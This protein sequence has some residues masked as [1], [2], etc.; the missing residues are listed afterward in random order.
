[1]KSFFHL[2]FPLMVAL[3]FGE[4]VRDSAAVESVTALKQES[5]ERDP[6]WEGYNN[7]V[8]PKRIPTVA[9]DFGYSPS[10]F[11]G[12]E[13]GEIGGRVWRS[14]TRASY[15]GAIPPRTLRDKLTASGTFAVTATS[16]SSGP[17][18]GWFNS[19]H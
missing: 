9:Q 3:T 12:K 18:F 6:K 11:A 2:A 14:S 7:H 19:E 4:A 13:K 17:F 10:N 1:M 15:A 16:G 8:T 5:F